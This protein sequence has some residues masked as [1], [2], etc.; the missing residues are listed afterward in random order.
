MLL[1]YFHAWCEKIDIF[2]GQLFYI[3]LSFLYSKIYR[4][5]EVISRYNSIVH[6]YYLKSFHYACTYIQ[7]FVIY[8]SVCIILCIFFLNGD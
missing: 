2:V 6:C 1:R 7:I 5:R 3:M 8:V 4:G